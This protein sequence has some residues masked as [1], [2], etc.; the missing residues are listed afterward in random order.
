MIRRPPRSTRTDTL[1]P[2][3][4]LFRSLEDP[5]VA[6][7][8]AL[9]ARAE[10]DEQLADRCLVAQAREGEAAV[11]DAVGLGHRDQ[12]LG[13][14]AQFL[15]LRQRGL[16]QPVLEQRGGHVGEHR[17]AVRAGAV[18]FASGFLVA[19]GLGSW[20]ILGLAEHAV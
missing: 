9:V 14:A 11:G 17:I 10:L 12:R 7:R 2:Y 13:D 18:E 3:T 6:A 19:H 4:T 5:Q 20:L 1:F 8:A 16:D 15:R